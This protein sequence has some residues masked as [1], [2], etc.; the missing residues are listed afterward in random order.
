MNA[1]GPQ[2]GE[3][4]IEIPKAISADSHTIEP[5]EAYAKHIDPAYRDRAAEDR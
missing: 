5:P 1:S 2:P 3:I 4:S